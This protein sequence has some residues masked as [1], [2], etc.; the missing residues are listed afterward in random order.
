MTDTILSASSVTIEINELTQDA[1]QPMLN[2]AE[3]SSEIGTDIPPSKA[4]ESSGFALVP[5]GFQENSLT[6]M[7]SSL[8]SV[9]KSIFELIFKNI[10]SVPPIIRAMIEMI[11]TL[12]TRDTVYCAL[13]NPEQIEENQRPLY[14]FS[15]INLSCERFY[16]QSCCG[17]LF[18]RLLCPA[19]VCPMEWGALKPMNKDMQVSR[20]ISKGSDASCPE[21]MQSDDPSLNLKSSFI[22]NIIPIITQNITVLNYFQSRKQE[23]ASSTNNNNKEIGSSQSGESDNNIYAWMDPTD[24]S[25]IGKKSYKIIDTN[26]ASAALILVA[27]ILSSDLTVLEELDLKLSVESDILLSPTAVLSEVEIIDN[28]ASPSMLTTDVSLV[29]K[30]NDSVS[31]GRYMYHLNRLKDIIPK[32]IMD[33]ASQYSDLISIGIGVSAQENSNSQ[34][35]TKLKK[36]QGFASIILAITENIPFSTVL[37]IILFTKKCLYCCLYSTDDFACI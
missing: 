7:N 29:S 18:L 20:N 13:N 35:K 25:K 16:C 19:L 23:P 5:I 26:R 3:V 6:L 33:K 31:S 32:G 11:Y 10:N 2:D 22:G 30:A 28:G 12:I 27:H 9:S 15:N 14:T 36:T 24:E 34:L 37:S 17:I 21:Q 1:E 8:L 4:L